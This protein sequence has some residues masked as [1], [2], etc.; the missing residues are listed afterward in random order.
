[1][2][3]PLKTKA[4]M[5][6]Q[7]VTNWLHIVGRRSALRQ[8]PLRDDLAIGKPLSQLLATRV[9]D[10]CVMNI[11]H[12]Q[13]RQILEMRD[14]RV[15]DLRIVDHERIQFGQLLQ[16]YQTLIGNQRLTKKQARQIRQA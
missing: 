8:G 15:A 11:E 7:Y 14:A 13:I 16:M 12:A 4:G 2:P 1:M 9:A 10:L 6:W 5:P 3:R